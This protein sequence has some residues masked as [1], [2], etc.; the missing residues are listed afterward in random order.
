MIQ[1]C[2]VCTS[3]SK[4]ARCTTENPAQ[5]LNCNYGDYLTSS[6]VCQACATGCS[7]CLSASLCFG[8]SSGYVA[9]QAGSISVSS[10]TQPV[11]TYQPVKCLACAQ[12]CLTCY[13][14][15]YI[16]ASCISGYNFSQSLC[17]SEFNYAFTVVLNP[18]ANTSFIYNFYDFLLAVA[19]AAG[20][21]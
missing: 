17:V 1:T 3:S 15:P 2:I 10:S 20:I 6:N 19:N 5:C 9:Q 13:N 11:Q 21:N 8:C 14:S 4:C 16:C 7:N 12:P 18:P